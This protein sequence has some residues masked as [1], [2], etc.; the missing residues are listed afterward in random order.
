MASRRT[1]SQWGINFIKG[2]E[3]Y[4]KHP[5]KAVSTEQYYTWGWGHYGADVPSDTSASI[6][7]AEADALFVKDLAK[8]EAN[9][10][11]YQI[12]YGWNQNQFDALVSFAYN[13]GSIDQLV[14]NGKRTNAEI[15]SVWTSYNKS[16]GVVLAGL[17]AR[18]KAELAHFKS[19]T[20]TTSGYSWKDNVKMIYAIL[21]SELGSIAAAGILGNM[22]VECP[23]LYGFQKQGDFTA[24]RK[25]SKTYTTNINNGTTSK[26]T[27]VHDSI[28]YGLSQWTY[29]T[30]K[31]KL[32][33]Y[34][35]EASTADSIG[36]TRMQANYALWSLKND[37]PSVYTALKQADSLRDATNI[38]L[39]DY[40]NPAE[41]EAT[42]EQRY[43]YAVEVFHYCEGVEPD[44][45][46]PEPTP[47][48]TK[49]KKGMSLIYWGNPWLNYL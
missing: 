34:W 12:S 25:A 36:N 40:E 10:N 48:P 2:Y 41:L 24:S 27:F 23:I 13:I 6:S 8:F 4:R 47:K 20:T 9:V 1:T 44:P 5:Y 15:E 26:D 46:P 28:G 29:Y 33:N 42:R 21:S 35:K 19:T 3:T 32:Y 43:N 18:R 37:Y 17:T 16:S 31:E 39:D 49:K 45:D 7:R 22:R 38:Y 14:Q 30:L 11:K